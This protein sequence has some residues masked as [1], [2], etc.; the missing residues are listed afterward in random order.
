MILIAIELWSILNLLYLV[1]KSR[2]DR[3]KRTAKKLVLSGISILVLILIF[4]MV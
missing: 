2:L 1:E 4:Y 3:I